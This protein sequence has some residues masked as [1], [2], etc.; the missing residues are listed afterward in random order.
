[1]VGRTGEGQGTQASRL[2][3]QGQKLWKNIFHK[4][5]AKFKRYMPLMNCLIEV[6]M[7]VPF[8]Q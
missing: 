7:T 1:M 3:P 4:L 5:N 2:E 6:T 8:H